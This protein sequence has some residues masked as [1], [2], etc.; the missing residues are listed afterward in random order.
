AYGEIPVYEKV[1]KW[2]KPS[3]FAAYHEDWF[4]VSTAIKGFHQA[5]LSRAEYFHLYPAP[6]ADGW[7]EWKGGECPVAPSDI[8]EYLMINDTADELHA[9][10]AGDLQWS[11]SGS[12]G[13][14]AFYRLYKSRS[15]QEVVSSDTEEQQNPTIEKL[16]A[17]YRN[18]LDYA[19][20]KQDEADKANMESDAALSELEKAIAAI[21]FA[22]TPIGVVAQEPA[23]ANPNWRNWLRGDEIKCK[24][25][26][27]GAVK[28]IGLTGLVSKVYGDFVE[29]AFEHHVVVAYGLLIDECFEF[30]SRP[31]K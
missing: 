18:K 5:I 26:P 2:H 7:I 31:A 13:D 6:D 20:L 21:G 4:Q 27:P 22:I 11:K 10:K 24:K 25:T 17:D 9:D 3:D 1:K 19:D 12:A 16:V 29:I 28:S 30:V 14:I 23:R 8:V 15:L